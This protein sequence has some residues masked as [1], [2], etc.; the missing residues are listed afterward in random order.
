MK[1]LVLLAMMVAALSYGMRDVS[2]YLVQ[3]AKARPVIDG[4][5]SEIAWKG[6]PK[7]AS[8]YEY[9]KAEPARS[10]LKSSF[11]M[12]YDAKGVYLAIENFDGSINTIRKTMTDRDNPNLWLDDC[13]EIYIDPFGS[14]IGFIKF[15]VNSIGTFRDERRID[16]SVTEPNWN[17]CATVIKAKILKDKWT[18]EAFFPWED[19]GRAAKAGDVW[20]FCH[21]RY[22]FSSGAF[23]GATSAP[24][25][26]YAATD[27]FGFLRFMAEGESLDTDAI[28]KL[29]TPLVSPPW[30]MALDG[31]LLH[32]FGKGLQKRSISEMVAE[33]RGRVDTLANDGDI[34]GSTFAKE[35]DALLE[36]SGKLLGESDDSFDRYKALSKMADEL[37][38]FKW[39]S[40]LEAEFNTSEKK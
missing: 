24:G 21:V 12:C 40:R 37:S 35:R 18:I 20:R 15:T 34:K 5:I 33:I 27:C 29:L 11:A 14:A 4:D 10:P 28:G 8:Y 23:V 9:F 7:H 6:V 1:K 36:K 38:E 16:A 39:K 31:T 30:A 26:N 19:M 17:S 3:P 13:A 22:A 2:L 32:N 25:G